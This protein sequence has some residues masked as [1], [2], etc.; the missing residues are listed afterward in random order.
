M[1]CT[2]QSL[3]SGCPRK[4]LPT[5]PCV[6]VVAMGKC[7][8]L[9]SVHT[10]QGARERESLDREEAARRGY[11]VFTWVREPLGAAYSGYTEV[12][13]RTTSSQQQH[14]RVAKLDCGAGNAR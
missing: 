11:K 1:I 7:I 9:P 14:T 10:N 2:T 13:H 4:E 5:A 8:S 12:T 3:G 6:S